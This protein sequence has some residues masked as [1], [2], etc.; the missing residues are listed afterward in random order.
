[1]SALGIIGSSVMDDLPGFERSP[2]EVGLGWL[3]NLDSADFVGRD[4]LAA[5]QEN[6]P[7]Y[8]LRSFELD[9]NDPP[10]DGAILRDG[11]SEN[12]DVVGMVNCCHWSW[13]LNKVIGNASIQTQLA[14][15]DSAW[16]TI[17]G[18]PVEVNLSCGPLVTLERRNQV[19]APVDF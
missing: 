1:M 19:P 16:V 2:Y 12:A 11:S 5:Q 18:D 15:L 13:G 10:D 9:A 17:N 6:G 4:A 8:T 7:P 14:N 3:V